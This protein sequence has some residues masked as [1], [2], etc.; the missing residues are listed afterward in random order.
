[1]TDGGSSTTRRA[2]SASIR[3]ATF[4]CTLSAAIAAELAQRLAV[5]DAV[6]QAHDWLHGAIQAADDLAIGRG[7]GPVHHFYALWPGR[8]GAAA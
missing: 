4:G 7:N 8:A 1:M 6:G 3:R 5:A 2:A